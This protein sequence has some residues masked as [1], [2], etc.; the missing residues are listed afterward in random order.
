MVIEHNS[1]LFVCLCIC[2]YIFFFIMNHYSHESVHLKRKFV[3]QI[4]MHHQIIRSKA[5]ADRFTLQGEVLS[6]GQE[7]DF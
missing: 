6:N 2:R 1:I 5:L 4:Q 7:S 3:S